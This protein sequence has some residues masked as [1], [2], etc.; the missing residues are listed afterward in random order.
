MSGRKTKQ[1]SRA[2]EFRQSLLAWKQT[3]VAFR[4]SLRAL[5]R[6]LATSHQLLSHYLSGLEEWHREKELEPLRAQAKAKNLTLT[7]EDERRYLA[8]LR[9]IEKRQANDAARAAKWASK[10]AALLARLNHLLPDSWG[11][12]DR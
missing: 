6:E 7:S 8:W 11:D 4:P 2:V 10:H 9:R 12:F 3:P 5:A 1:E